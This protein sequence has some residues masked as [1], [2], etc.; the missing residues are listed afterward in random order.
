[1]TD[2]PYRE[3][4]QRIINIEEALRTIYNLHSCKKVHDAE[5]MPDGCP[6][7]KALENL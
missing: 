6:I 5:T 2:E 7:C 1:M 4:Q 3:L